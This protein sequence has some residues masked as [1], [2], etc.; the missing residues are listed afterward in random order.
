[1]MLDPHSPQLEGF[2]DHPVDCLKVPSYSSAPQPA[3]SGGTSL[4]YLDQE[5][6][7]RLGGGEAASSFEPLFA[8]HGR[9]P[10]RGR[11]Q[12]VGD[13]RQL[14]GARVRHDPQQAQEDRRHGCTNT[15]HHKVRSKNGSNDKSNQTR[16][17]SVAPEDSSH[18]ELVSHDVVRPPRSAIQPQ[19]QEPPEMLRMTSRMVDKYLKVVISFIG[20]N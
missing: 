17:S 19:V 14:T 10:G 2:F 12:E 15:G 18:D 4:L 20:R 5:P 3:C 11:G 9:L 16:E 8:V 7:P 6:H 1:M 13:D